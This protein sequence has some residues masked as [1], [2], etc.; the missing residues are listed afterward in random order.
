MKSRVS[1]RGEKC[2]LVCANGGFSASASSMLPKRVCKM[3]NGSPR[4]DQDQEPWV[5]IEISLQIDFS[6]TFGKIG[7]KRSSAS[8]MAEIRSIEHPTLKVSRNSSIQ[9]VQRPRSVQRKPISLFIFAKCLLL[10][11]EFTNGTF[12]GS[13]RDPQQ[14]VSHDTKN[15]RPRTE[16]N[17]TKCHE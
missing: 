13:L 15:P 7:T 12:L 17:P 5:V 16:R 14:K 6:K 10:I 2:S 11:L 4:Q 9:P 1:H 3:E 8:E